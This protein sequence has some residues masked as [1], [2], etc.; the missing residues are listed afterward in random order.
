MT[1]TFGLLTLNSET[2]FNSSDL[3]L[4]GVDIEGFPGPS[5]GE[6]I[7]Q[8]ARSIGA[9]ELSP[10]GDCSIPSRVIWDGDRNFTSLAM[11][12]EAHALGMSVKVWNVSS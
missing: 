11:V 5:P 1:F 9:N 3:W 8:A 6:K 10:C 2:A 7:A 12:R 4:G